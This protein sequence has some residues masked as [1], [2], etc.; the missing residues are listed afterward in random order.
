MMHAYMELAA[1]T[2]ADRLREAEQRRLLRQALAGRAERSPR[3]W[4]RRE[5][6]NR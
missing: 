1:F 5:V 2:H 3:R 4:L 6:P